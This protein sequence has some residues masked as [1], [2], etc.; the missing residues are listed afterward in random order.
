MCEEF[1]CVPSVAERE[2]DQHGELVFDIVDLR[3]Y[4]R[5]FRDYK[6]LNRLDA[7]GR[8]ELLADEM[9]QAVRE[10]D[11]AL[12]TGDHSGRSDGSSG[13]GQPDPGVQPPG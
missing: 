7:K 4:A 6:G 8:R 10:N 13:T 12:A 3:A 5:A 1:G 11:F 9:V 2:I